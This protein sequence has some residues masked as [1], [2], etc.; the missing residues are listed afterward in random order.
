LALADLPPAAQAL[1]VKNWNNFVYSRDNE[2]GAYL[3]LRPDGYRW[4]W[5]VGNA[6]SRPFWSLT[7]GPQPPG[8]PSETES[9][10]RETW[11]RN[12]PDGKRLLELHDPATDHPADRFTLLSKIG[13]N[14]TTR[15][16]VFVVWATVGFFEVDG[17]N[18]LGRELGLAD[19]RQRRHR[20][21]AV[22][23]RSVYSAYQPPVP[24]TLNPW[25]KYDP[26]RDYQ[27]QFDA[28]LNTYGP[29]ASVLYWSFID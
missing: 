11:L 10:L 27:T 28:D 16:N 2:K 12:G 24:G 6:D 18:R 29:P 4:P 15:S 17:Q 23:D 22:I 9:G 14:I 19:G 3:E 26:R 13:N 7:A 20:F 8:D 25:A 21:F 1:L 5:R